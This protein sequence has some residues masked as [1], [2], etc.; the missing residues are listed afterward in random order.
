MQRLYSRTTEQIAMGGC[1]GGGVLHWRH[2]HN[3]GHICQLK[4]VPLHHLHDLLYIRLN[5]SQ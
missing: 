3:V 2:L 4:H 5:R 1:G